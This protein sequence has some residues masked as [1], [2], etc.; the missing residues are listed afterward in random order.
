MLASPVVSCLVAFA[1]EPSPKKYS[2]KGQRRHAEVTLLFR[3][4][5]YVMLEANICDDRG[6]R[7]L[8]WLFGYI[9]I[10]GERSIVFFVRHLKFY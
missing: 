3:I 8:A 10:V 7:A 4:R 2:V 6:H 5:K 9:F 1:C